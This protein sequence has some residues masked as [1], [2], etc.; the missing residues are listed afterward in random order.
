M[1]CFS[2]HSYRSSFVNMLERFVPCKCSCCIS[3]QRGTGT[4]T[5]AAHCVGKEL[6]EETSTGE[7]FGMERKW[8]SQTHN[9][10]IKNTCC[11]PQ[12]CQQLLCWLKWGGY[13]NNFIKFLVRAAINF[14][15]HWL[16][17]LNHRSVS[18]SWWTE[19][20]YRTKKPCDILS[21]HWFACLRSIKLSK[22]IW[23]RDLDS[24]IMNCSPFPP[25]EH[26][27]PHRAAV[28]PS[29]R[30]RGS[31]STSALL[32]EFVQQK[33]TS[34]C[35]ISHLFEVLFIPGAGFCLSCVTQTRK[36]GK[37]SGQTFPVQLGE[38]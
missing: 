13:E 37:S 24:D 23:G 2:S 6:P 26:P 33:S 34:K 31:S 17:T 36:T 19:K 14:C 27:L 32:L 7:Q 5:N 4:E 35:S 15:N 10:K 16:F 9:G 25:P 18:G 28:S 8:T 12:R 29:L 38:I 1:L 20:A 11:F 30:G 21:L 22:S 3:S